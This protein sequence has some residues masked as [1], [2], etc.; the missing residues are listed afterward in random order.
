MKYVRVI[1]SPEAADA[2]QD[3]MNKASGS[4]QE[5]AILNSF[6]Q[7]VELLK[8]NVHYG[9][10]ISKKLIPAEYKTRYGI[11]N[12]FRARVPHRE[13]GVRFGRCTPSSG[14]NF[15][16]SFFIFSR[17]ASSSRH[18]PQTTIPSTRQ[19]ANYTAKLTSQLPESARTRIFLSPCQALESAVNSLFFHI[20]QN[21]EFTAANG[22]DFFYVF[23][24]HITRK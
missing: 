4:K 12:L 15:K 18:F 16:N 14:R 7:K 23:H 3:L 11:T 10:P 19:T 2:Y 21:K 8:E 22:A 5:E 17:S 6:L 24:K 9:Q 13:H 1:L 20:V